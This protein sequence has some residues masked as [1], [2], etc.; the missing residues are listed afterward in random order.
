MANLPTNPGWTR[1]N[2]PYSLAG[3]TD[4]NLV[5]NTILQN[6][7]VILINEGNNY[8]AGPIGLGQNSV[9]LHHLKEADM[10]P[11]P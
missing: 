10:I 3:T 9:F 4:I 1:F 6:M 2:P 7:F 11:S 8:T 5:S